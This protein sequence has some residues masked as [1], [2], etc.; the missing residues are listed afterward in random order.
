MAEAIFG[1]MEQIKKQMKHLAKIC[2][3]MCAPD[4]SCVQYWLLP[5]RAPDWYRKL[6]LGTGSADVHVRSA[7]KDSLPLLGHIDLAVPK[8]EDAKLF[9]MEGLGCGETYN[10]STGQLWAHMGPSQIRFHEGNATTWPGEIRVWVEDI[11]A[12]ADML[13]MLGRTLDTKIV[14]EMRE[15]RTGG[16]YAA[17]LHDAARKNKVEASEAPSGW[18]PAIWR[19]ASGPPCKNALALSDAIIHLP[20]RTQVQ[21]VA[22]FYEHYI[23]SAIT[24]KYAVYEAQALMDICMVHFGPG[25]KLHQTLTYKAD[26]RYTVP[27]NL[28]SVCIYV[29]DHVQFHLVFAKCKS[30]GLLS[31][32]CS[33]KSWEEIESHK[34]FTITGVMDPQDHSIVIALPHII[35]TKDHPECPLS[36]P[37]PSQ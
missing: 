27:S 20:K 26:L 21:G 11:R 14:E 2:H 4:Q 22:R 24:K 12:V 3:D 29:V 37:A 31:P 28:A 33:K 34:E 18:G 16:E 25:S 32:N 23:G 17:L 30:S 6:V 35:R 5:E 13:N 36:A 15:A 8:L 1:A 7:P 19:I 9:W 10:P